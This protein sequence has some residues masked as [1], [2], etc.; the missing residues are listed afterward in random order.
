MWFY[1]WYLLLSVGSKSS[2]LLDGLQSS[3]GEE[4]GFRCSPVAVG[5][6][7]LLVPLVEL[8]EG[9]GMVPDLHAV[10][11]RLSVLLK[12]SSEF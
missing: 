5:L 8:M 4:E 6:I 2:F 12:K 10:G 9:P 7:P 11:N 1:N 3:G